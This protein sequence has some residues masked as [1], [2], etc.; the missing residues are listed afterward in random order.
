MLITGVS[1]LLGNN[2]A[3]YFK[4]KY[5]IVGLYNSRPVTI[6]GIYTERCQLSHP[7]QIKKIISDYDP[8]VIIHC[9]SL[10]NIDECEADKE[11]TKKVNVLA[12][13]D[14]VEAVRDV[15]VKLIYISSDSVYEGVKGDYSEDDRIGPQNYY[16]LSKYEGELEVF[17]KEN[18][19]V[20]RT[21]I[22]GWNIQNKKSLGEWILG[23]LKAKQRINGFKDAYFST[24]Y[25]MELTRVIDISIKKNLTGVYNCG[26]LDP[27]S[28]Y[29]FSLRIADCFGFDKT[30]ITPIS[31]DDSNFKA[32]RGKNLTLNVNKLQKTLDYKLPTINHSIEAFYRDYKCGLPEEIKKNQVEPREPSNLIP[33]GSQWIDIKD[34]QS[35]V[36]V[37]RSRKITQGPQVE[38]FE[39]TLA[40]YCRAKYAVAVNSGTSALHIACRAAGVEDGDEVITSPITFVASANCAVYCGAK[41]IFADI[42]KRTYNIS[43]EEIERKITERTRAIIPVHFAGQSC[44]M[45]TISQVVRSAEKKY[46]HKIFIIEDACHALGSKYQNTQVGSCPFSDM[47]VLSFH[48]VKHITTGEGGAILTNDEKLYRKLKRFRS[49]GITSTPG[50]FVYGNLAFQA[51]VVSLEALM[52]P[53]YYEQVDLGYNYRITDI[54][55]ALGLSQLRKLNKFREHRRKIVNRYNQAFSSIES[56]RTPFESEDCDSN[57]HL[58]VLLFDF[59]RIGTPR[60]EFMNKLKRRG[61]QTQVHYIPVHTQPY[62]QQNFGTKWGDYPNAEE[63]YH[64]CLSIP[65]FPVMTELDVERVINEITDLARG[66]SWT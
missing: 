16:G 3:Y 43:P 38:E 36:N 24:I 25:T 18:A 54:Q 60:A 41:P 47:T 10:T 48:P 66:K 14:I 23:E 63:Y 49:H 62:Y 42:D 15:D 22:F 33:Y 13:K 32:K 52:N 53:W 5:E 59:D 40:E 26:G 28:K 12:T 50:E 21:N 1:G 61:I 37:L 58:Y 4:D 7:D 55:C 44:D 45:V 17:K 9:A 30:L 11:T 6:D 31:I 51:T 2:L 34:I 20:F 65:L 64:K 39:N 56:V 19:L 29:E 35:V 57:F 8:D 46:G 27:C